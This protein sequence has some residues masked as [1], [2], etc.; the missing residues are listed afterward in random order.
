MEGFKFLMDDILPVT[1]P[2][3]VRYIIAHIRCYSM[4]GNVSKQLHSTF[5]VGIKLFVFFT[6]QVDTISQNKDLPRYMFMVN[7]GHA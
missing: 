6:S 4:G 3:T 2:M 7:N 1:Y 5:G